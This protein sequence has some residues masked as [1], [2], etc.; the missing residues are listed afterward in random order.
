MKNG[1]F[2]EDGQLIYYKNDEPKHAGVIRENGDIYY[3]SSGGR[4]VKGEH[5]VHGEMANG[6]LKRGTYTFGEDYKLV[7]GSYV[8]PRKHRKKRR[9][10]T[11]KTPRQR[12]Q[13]KKNGILWAVMA[14]ILLLALLLLLKKSDTLRTESGNFQIGEIGEIGDIGEIGEIGAP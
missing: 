14:L 8:A 2:T 12:V 1:L 10:R 6:I 13:V 11:E 4:A 5:I 9:R 3:I 7:K